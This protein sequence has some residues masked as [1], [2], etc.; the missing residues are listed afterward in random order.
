M[1]KVVGMVLL[2]FAL[3]AVALYAGGWAIG[4]LWLFWIAPIIGAALGAAVYRF[5]GKEAV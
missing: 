3:S 5:I 2:V 4:Q 1:K